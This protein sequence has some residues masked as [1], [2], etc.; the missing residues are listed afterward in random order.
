VRFKVKMPSG[1]IRA[2]RAWSRAHKTYF[3]MEANLP[4]KF[5][6]EEAMH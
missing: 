2:L 5:G 3:Q 6:I 4:C 1:S